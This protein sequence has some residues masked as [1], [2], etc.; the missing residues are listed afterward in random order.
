MD[1]WT[2]SNWDRYDARQEHDGNHYKGPSSD[3][4]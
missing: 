3:E 1:A 2:E 4:S